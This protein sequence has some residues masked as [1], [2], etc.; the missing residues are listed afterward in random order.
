MK[1][2]SFSRMKAYRK[3]GR[4][5]YILKVT[6]P[7]V[8]ADDGE[9]DFETFNSFYIEAF[10]AYSDAVAA[11]VDKSEN[12]SKAFKITVSFEEICSFENIIGIRRILS[13][14]TG[15]DRVAKED[16]DFY[17]TTCGVFIKKPKNMKKQRNLPSGNDI[18]VKNQH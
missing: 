9:K 3:D 18:N 2:S 10:A 17:N 7:F 5:I 11:L 14:R 13:Y 12:L 1:L 8:E 4:L 16:T 6:L 15:E